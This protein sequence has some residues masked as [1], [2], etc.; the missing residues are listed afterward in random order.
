MICTVCTADR[1]CAKAGRGQCAPCGLFGPSV[2]C[3]HGDGLCSRCDLGE[4]SVL[5]IV[6]KAVQMI[7][8]TVM[9][10]RNMHRLY[11]TFMSVDDLCELRSGRLYQSLLTPV[12]AVSLCSDAGL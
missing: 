6:C 12:A 7:F 1:R 8:G 9:R 2:P 10:C 3:T 11:R 4:Q 5:K